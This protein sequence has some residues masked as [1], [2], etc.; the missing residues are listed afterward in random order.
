MSD[1]CA[2]VPNCDIQ[3]DPYLAGTHGTPRH[4]L[5]A[6]DRCT[7]CFSSGDRAR[8]SHQRTLDRL[9]SSSGST[10]SCACVTSRRVWVD[11][12]KRTPLR[13]LVSW[14]RRLR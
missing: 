7:A 6:V 14:Y 12:M 5:M 3:T 13:S 2:L 10:Q 4:L 8:V 9:C 1:E 11:G